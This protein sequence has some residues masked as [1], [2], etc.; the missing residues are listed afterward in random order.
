M[1]MPKSLSFHE[2]RLNFGELDYFCSTF[3][4]FA[5]LITINFSD[6]FDISIVK[7]LVIAGLII[8]HLSI[9]Y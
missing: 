5:V 9:R 3:T 8:L 7:T 2:K 1:D 6:L 4:R